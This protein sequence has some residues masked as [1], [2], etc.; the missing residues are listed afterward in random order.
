MTT[1]I[2]SRLVL[3]LDVKEASALSEMLSEFKATSSIPIEDFREA[4]I[5]NLRFFISDE[6]KK[7]PVNQ[8]HN[9]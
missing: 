7:S 9:L 8:S 4:L 5:Q 1:S 6:S 2:D 3:S